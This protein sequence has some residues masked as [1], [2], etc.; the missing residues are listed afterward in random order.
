MRSYFSLTAVDGYPA[1]PHK[2]PVFHS[3]VDICWDEYREQQ[4]IIGDALEGLAPQHPGF[5]AAV[6]DVLRGQSRFV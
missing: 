3:K 4:W 6:L 5:G 2:G 1:M